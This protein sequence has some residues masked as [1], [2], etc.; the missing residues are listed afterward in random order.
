MAEETTPAAGIPEAT[1]MPHPTHPH[2]EPSPQRWAQE[3]L[4][5]AAP[6]GRRDWTLLHLALCVGLAMGALALAARLLA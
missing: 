2:A 1:P 6:A 3:E 4:P 5:L